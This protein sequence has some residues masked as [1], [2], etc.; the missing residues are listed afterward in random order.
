MSW[1]QTRDKLVGD[2]GH[3]FGNWGTGLLGI[4]GS[5]EVVHKML[6]LKYSCIRKLIGLQICLLNNSLGKKKWSIRI[7]KEFILCIH[8]QEQM[9][10]TLTHN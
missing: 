6:K 4:G 2:S 1:G 8:K 10:I 3:N 7:W 5:C 9:F